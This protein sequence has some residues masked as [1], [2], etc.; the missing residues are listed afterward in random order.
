MTE[1]P[2][3]RVAVTGLG[4]VSSIGIG[5]DAFTKSL[6]EGTVAVAPVGGFDT[7]GFPYVMASEVRDFDSGA[8]L[9]RL[10]ARQWGRSSLLG[11]AAARLAAADAGIS[12]RDLAGIRAGAIMGTTGGE[13]V[14]AQQLAAQWTDGGLASLDAALIPQL[15]ASQIANAV[16]T[17]LGLTGDTLTVPT[18]C[19]ASN[20]ALGYAYDLVRTGEADLMVAGGADAVNRNTHAG[21]YRLGALAEETCRPFDTHRSGILTGE[22]GVALLL[23]PLADAR[24][25]GAVIYAEVLGYGMNC[26]ARHMVHPDADGIA[27]CIR[28]AHRA[29]G[30]QP[31]Q[32]DYICA[33]GTGTPT[34]DATEVAAIRDVFGTDLPPISSIKSMIGHAM[35]AASG[36]GAVACCKAIHEGFLPP[37]ATLQEPDEALGPGIDFVPGKGRTAD[38]TIAQNHGFA[39]GGN[40]VIVLFGRLG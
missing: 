36:F 22:G 7:A 39:F 35:G 15:P 8:L 14:V 19:S 27:A 25:R 29:S 24:G 21:F 31:R 32:V 18:A 34:N 16:S 23:E 4:T 26:D 30:V 40:N 37:T 10:D 38:V 6:R 13:S 11:A 2:D 12:E 28:M 17:E 1:A 5:A 33:H 20:F 9:T 3:R